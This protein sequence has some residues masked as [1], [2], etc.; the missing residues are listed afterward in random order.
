MVP[1]L[2]VGAVVSILLAFVWALTDAA[3]QRVSRVRAGDLADE[4]RRGG[5]ALVKILD[6]S[7]AYLSVTAFLRTIA[8]SIAAVCVTLAVTAVVD[9]FWPS[10]FT[11]TGTMVLLSFVAVGVSPRTLGRLHSDAVAL[12]M[13]PLVVGS[14][15]VRSHGYSSGSP[16][17][18][19]RDRVTATGRF[20][21]SPNSATSSTWRA[22]AR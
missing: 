21:T 18:S 8:E 15:L 19:P 6:D 20:R 3:L 10:L 2:V 12:A 5:P 17:S 9:G 22:R 4:G 7:A 14:R 11:A 1:Q 13:A 16:T